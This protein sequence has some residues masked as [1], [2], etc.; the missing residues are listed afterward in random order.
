M[1]TPTVLSRTPCPR[2]TRP[3]PSPMAGPVR[4]RHRLRRMQR[5]RNRTPH[6][7]TPSTPTCRSVSSTSIALTTAASSPR[8]HR[9]DRMEREIV[10]RVVVPRWLTNRWALAVAVLLGSAG[11]CYAVVPNVFKPGDPLSASK[12]MEDL[13]SLDSRVANSVDLTT[14]QDIYGRKTFKDV[15][16]FNHK[17]YVEHDDFGAFVV[18]GS[19][20][21]SIGIELTNKITNGHSWAIA[22][23][24]PAGAAPLGALIIF[25]NTVSG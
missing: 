23:S 2:S 22:S 7:P 3:S 13:N 24:G 8:S 18:N 21:N 20:T 25:D 5:H 10:I 16:L 15:T 1:R 17:V 11:L 12:L 4:T 14:W 19:G 9:R 6:N